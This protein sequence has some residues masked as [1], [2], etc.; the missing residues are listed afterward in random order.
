MS[1]EPRER[2]GRY[3]LIERIALGGMAEVWRARASAADSVVKDVA[4]KRPLSRYAAD[5]DFRKMFMMR[6]DSRLRCRIPILL[7]SSSW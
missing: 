1:S 3:E 6:R 4:L 5:D 2:C 7:K